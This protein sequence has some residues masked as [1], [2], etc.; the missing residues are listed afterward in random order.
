M[1]EVY[2]LMLILF[3]FSFGYSQNNEEDIAILTHL[4]TV[5]W[6]KAYRE[7]DN[8]L[9]DR[10][11]HENFEMI[12]AQGMSYTKEDELKYIKANK[13]DYTSFEY[14]IERLDIFENGTAVVAGKGV[15]ENEDDGG[16]YI[17]SY[18][19][20]NILIKENGL[21]Q[22]IASH[23]SGISKKYDRESGG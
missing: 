16:P 10:I 18:M 23:V 7:Q 2:T 21:W 17:L 11:L 14:K 4:K 8:V 20:S 1:K 19:S 15:I 3:V 13:P 22:A 12:D 5:D 9:L 6:P